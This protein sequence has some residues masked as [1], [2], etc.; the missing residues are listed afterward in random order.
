M[1]ILYCPSC[2]AE[3]AMERSVCQKC[4]ADLGVVK[5]I[6]DTASLHYN[7]ALSL[8]GEGRY[9]EAEL[10]AL[11][12]LELY[13]RDP[14]FHNLLGT[15]YARQGKFSRAQEAWETTLH[16]DEHTS[17]AYR[18]LSRLSRLST[19]SDGT[20]PAAVRPGRG[21]GSFFA[22][23]LLLLFVL[24][25]WMAHH[26]SIRQYED[27]IA[28][29]RRALVAEQALKQP[30]ATQGAGPADSGDLADRVA[31][32]VMQ[33]LGGEPAEPVLFWDRDTEAMTPETA[34]PQ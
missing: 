6:L 19:A 23:I 16:L 31:Q 3:N 2:G 27:I 29:Q 20:D 13:N 22:T 15:I 33:L 7:R 5:S 25:G 11:S 14:R 24:V 34:E 4:K 17:S 26:Y 30:A 18:S 28:E 32:R 1:N 12:A 10:E 8:A 21:A 9:P